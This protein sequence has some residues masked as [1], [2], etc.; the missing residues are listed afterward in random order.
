MKEIYMRTKILI[1]ST[2]CAVAASVAVNAQVYSVNAVGYVNVTCP[3]GFSI[4]ANPLNAVT[5]TLSALIP[6]PT[7]QTTVYEWANNNYSIATFYA[8][9][10]T[11]GSW[12]NDLVLAPGIGAWIYNPGA[13]PFTITFVGEVTQGT[14]NVNLGSGYSLVSSIVPQGG[15]LDSLLGYVPSDQDTV[16]QYQN[17]NFVIGTY[18]A[19]SPTTGSWDNIPTP[20]VGEGFW[21]YTTKP[22][23]WTR[24]FSI[25]N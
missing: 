11:S 1:L 23:A 24:I 2:A 10:P 12:D 21:I 7:D 13:A 16:Y 4:I 25:N 22:K 20:A 14:N 17:G 18:Y 8:D 6:N 3:R 19:D 9:S 15:A 5:N